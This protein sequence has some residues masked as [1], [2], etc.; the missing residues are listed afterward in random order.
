LSWRAIAL[1]FAWEWTERSVPLGRYCLS[2][3]SAFRFAGQQDI[4]EDITYVF[5]GRNQLAGTY[6]GV[7]EF[8]ALLA[9]AKELSG[10]TASLE[11]K[12]LLADDEHVMMYARFRGE[13]AGRKVDYDHVYLY[14]FANGVLVEG[15]TI[16]VGQ[17][18]SDQFWG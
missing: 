8:W 14:R 12:V 7:D 16:P 10:G 1:N 5:H 9:K 13:R 4:A 6:R 2:N 18:L 11:P 17:A 3:R 15:H